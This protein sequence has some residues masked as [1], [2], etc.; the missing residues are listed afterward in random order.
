[1][2]IIGYRPTAAALAWCREHGCA[3][4]L[5]ERAGQYQAAKLTAGDR[6][7]GRA[8]KHLAASTRAELCAPAGL[9]LFEPVY[10]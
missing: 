10:R 9:A 8:A 5:G 3:G 7:G 6:A 1:M 4:L 2:S